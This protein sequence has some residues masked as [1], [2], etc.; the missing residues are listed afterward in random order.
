MAFL[1]QV[2]ERMKNWSPP[3][4]PAC[5]RVLAF[6]VEDDQVFRCVRYVL[7]CY[8]C[9][10][11]PASVG[12]S[13][14]YGVLMNA[15]GR[16]ADIALSDAVMISWRKLEA[17]AFAKR[18]GA[19]RTA[20]FSIV[21]ASDSPIATLTLDKLRA[22]ADALKRN[23]LLAP[24]DAE[25]LLFDRTKGEVF[26]ADRFYASFLRPLPASNLS[27]P[28]APEPLRRSRRITLEDAP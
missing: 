6:S 19:L 25:F 23:D 1:R 22:A 10:P 16:W 13:V 15:G 24:A 14:D 21:P 9:Y 26:A 3:P 17:Y 5:G 18:A 12:G 2:L 7:A 8:G 28:S 20:A 27:S 11:E 4:C